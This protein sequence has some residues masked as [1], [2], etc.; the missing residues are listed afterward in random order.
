MKVMTDETFG[1]LLP[2]MKVRDAEE[3]IELANDTRYGLNSSVFTQDVEKGER[4]ARRLSAGNACVND[5]LMNYLAQEAPFGG[6][7][8]SGLGARHGAD[9]IRKYCSRQTIL[10]TRFALEPGADDVPQRRA[11]RRSCSSG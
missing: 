5:A 11:A 9:G 7:G 10:I 4:I 8:E 6:T 2:V 3:A 1:P